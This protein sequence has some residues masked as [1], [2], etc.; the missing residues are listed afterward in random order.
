MR[1]ALAVGPFML[2]LP[3][4]EQEVHYIVWP[5]ASKTL[6]VSKDP[7]KD[8]KHLE[9]AVSKLLSNFPPKPGK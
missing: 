2:S 9:K 3:L 4:V 7:D 6:N 8:Y 5:V 1:R